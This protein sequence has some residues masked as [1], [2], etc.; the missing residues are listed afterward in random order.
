MRKA[1]LGAPVESPTLLSPDVEMLIKKTT[2]LRAEEMWWLEFSMLLV[3]DERQR[4]DPAAWP[5]GFAE[6]YAR[7]SLL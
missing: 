7:E 3:G 4:C 1:G 5:P 2:E 6:S